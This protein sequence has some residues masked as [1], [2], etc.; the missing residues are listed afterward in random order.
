MNVP[1][2][3]QHGPVAVYDLLINPD[4]P[5]L[6]AMLAI[7]AELFPQYAHYVPRMRQRAGRPAVNEQGH[8]VHYWLAEVDGQ[9]A[10]IRTFRYIPKRRCGIAISLA[11]LPK[12]RAVMVN[13][14]RLAVYIIYQCLDQVMQDARE[15]GNPAV[16][17][18]VNEVESERL[19]QH[20]LRSGHIELPIEYVEPIFP[21]AKNLTRQELLDAL[22]FSRMHLGFLPNPEYKDRQYTHHELRDFALAFLVDHYEIPENHPA[23]QSMLDSIHSLN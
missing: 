20:N 12:F 6:E 23:V 11:V 1:P 19:M 8:V 13:D 21:D 2:V 9:P 18:M 14:Q 17:G 10:G 16:F 4:P 22:D 3:R 15:A 7:Y 5:R